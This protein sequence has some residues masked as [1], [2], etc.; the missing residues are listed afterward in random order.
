M[1][2]ESATGYNIGREPGAQILGLKFTCER[3]EKRRYKLQDCVEKQRNGGYRLYL[4]L[5]AKLFLR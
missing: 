1:C 5:F 3:T 2:T 4:L